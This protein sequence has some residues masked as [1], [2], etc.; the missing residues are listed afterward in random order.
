MTPYC[1]LLGLF[2]CITIFASAPFTQTSVHFR[3]FNVTWQ[4]FSCGQSP[5]IIDAYCVGDSFLPLQLTLMHN[6][7]PEVLVGTEV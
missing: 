3:Y 6:N 5:P 4:P 7:Q 1:T 2:T